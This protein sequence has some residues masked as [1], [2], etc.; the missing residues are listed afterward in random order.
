MLMQTGCLEIS[1]ADKSIDDLLK[2]SNFRSNCNF[3]LLIN[4]VFFKF[5]QPGLNV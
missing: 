3:S 1:L 4:A 5:A 2:V